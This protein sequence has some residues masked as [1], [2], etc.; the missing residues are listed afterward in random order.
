[1]DNVRVS[2]FSGGEKIRNDLFV[3]ELLTLSLGKEKYEKIKDQVR[4]LSQEDLKQSTFGD[5][6]ELCDG[7]MQKDLYKVVQTADEL[8]N[9]L[10]IEDDESF[11]ANGQAKNLLYAGSLDQDCFSDANQYEADG[12]RLL[13]I[14]LQGRKS[15]VAAWLQRE[16]RAGKRISVLLEPGKIFKLK[17]VTICFLD[18]S[19]QKYREEILDDGD[20]WNELAELY[21]S[22]LNPRCSPS[23]SEKIRDFVQSKGG[24]TR[25]IWKEPNRIYYLTGLLF[26]V[27]AK[28]EKKEKT[29]SET[30]FSLYAKEMDPAL[31]ETYSGAI[32][33][34]HQKE[35]LYLRGLELLKAINP[36][37]ELVTPAIYLNSTPVL[38]EEK[39]ELKKLLKEQASCF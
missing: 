31:K 34:Y 18:A 2:F 37:L 7:K 26:K 36:N 22:S 35:E 30:L 6:M 16:A 20:L 17:S 15:C 10:L 4:I 27:F 3:Q 25:Y 38:E 21:W 12:T 13:Q 19:S 14:T 1:M 23:I 9:A 32:R 24:K 33:V 29:L 8:A 39:A 11:V 5:R 28:A